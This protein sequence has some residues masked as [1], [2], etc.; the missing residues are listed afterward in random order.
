MSTLDTK[1]HLLGLIETH[2]NVARV[3][4]QQI[5]AFGNNAS[6]Y[7]VSGA[8]AARL[9]I[10]RLIT[11]LK[12]DY[13]LEVTP[14]PVDESPISKDAEIQATIEALESALL[15]YDIDQALAL[16]QSLKELLL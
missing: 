1:K 6:P 16:T 9:E 7:M 12:T 8:N 4:D 10:Q 14:D 15:V 13:G 3:Y 2:R 5:A 11:R